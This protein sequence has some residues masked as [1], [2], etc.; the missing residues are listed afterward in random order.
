[1]NKNI[2]V[3]TKVRGIALFINFFTPNLKVLSSS[4]INVIECLIE[5]RKQKYSVKA[6]IGVKKKFNIISD[7]KSIIIIPFISKFFLFDMYK[8]DKKLKHNNIIKNSSLKTADSKTLKFKILNISFVAFL[9]NNN[10]ATI[11]DNPFKKNK[12]S[13]TKN[14][15]LNENTVSS[16]PKWYEATT[17]NK[18]KTILG[19]ANQKIIIKIE[20]S[21]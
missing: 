8:D 17:R 13:D 19:N 6:K 16:L 11:T 10:G 7:E 4:K 9:C 2:T 18:N 21:I 5:W 12:N 15:L 14:L 1:M 20:I 3:V